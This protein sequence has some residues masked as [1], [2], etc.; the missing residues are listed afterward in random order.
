MQFGT[1]PRPILQF[2]KDQ[3]DFPCPSLNKDADNQSVRDFEIAFAQAKS[4]Q[5]YDNVPA[6]LENTRYWY[7]GQPCDTY[8]YCCS[9][10]PE[11]QLFSFNGSTY[12]AIKREDSFKAPNPDSV[13]N[14][15]EHKVASIGV[16]KVDKTETDGGTD[17]LVTPITSKQIADEF[18]TR[19]RPNAEDGVLNWNYL[20]TELYK[21]FGISDDDQDGW[22][23]G[24]QPKSIQK[25]C[26][27]AKRE[28]EEAKQKRI[29]AQQ[30]PASEGQGGGE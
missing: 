11:A 10:V 26:D 27:K 13:G 22:A 23:K 8:R 9:Q 16:Y 20:A 29:D 28:A 14:Y 5:A 1:G 18:E 17:C 25:Q 3:T 24:E 2:Y 30:K 15:L 19:G 4:A 12:V 7:T 21:T 6:E